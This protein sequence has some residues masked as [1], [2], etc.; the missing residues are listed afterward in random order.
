MKKTLLIVIMTVLLTAGASAQT[1]RK[2]FTFNTRTWSTNYWTTLLYNLAHSA[3]VHFAFDGNS[4]D[5]L[6]VESILPSSD[7]VFPIGMAKAGFEAPMHDIYGPYHR[8]FSNPFKRI[9]DYGIGLDMSWK[10]VSIGLYAGAYFK[11][12]EIC[13][14]PNDESLRGFYFQPRAGLVLGGKEHALEAGVFYDKV[15]GCGG[16]WEARN[17]E[18]LQSGWG[19]DFALSRTVAKG[20]HKTMLMF[21]MPLHNFFN[22]AYADGSLKNVHRRVGY[23]M[24]THR[25]VL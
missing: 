22:T 13:F 5:S 17:I 8:A 9:G 2:Q 23:I 11:S 4:T 19:L 15:V 6:I 25:V 18:M 3:V 21:S 16:T 7:L 10:P 20:R 12:Q 1:T 14:M 24:L